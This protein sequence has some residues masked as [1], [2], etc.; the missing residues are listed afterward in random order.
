[1]LGL[2]NHQV[3]NNTDIL[4]LIHYQILIKIKNGNY[5]ASCIVFY[6]FVKIY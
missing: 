5:I 4:Q 3:T 6:Y 1:M 2:D